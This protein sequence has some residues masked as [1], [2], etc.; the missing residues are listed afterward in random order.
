MMKGIIL[1]L[2]KTYRCQNSHPD[3]YQ[4]MAALLFERHVATGGIGDDGY[5]LLADRKLSQPPT[6]P[7]Q[8]L[9]PLSNKERRF[10]H[11]QYH[12]CNI[13]H[14]EIRTIYNDTYGE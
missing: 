4:K 5:I 14:I 3:D 10:I 6:A 7:L 13:P 1:S 2:M 8:F 11:V 9:M 12:P